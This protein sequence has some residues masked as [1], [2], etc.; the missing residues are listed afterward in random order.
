MNGFLTK[1]LAAV[2]MAASSTA[3]FG[4]GQKGHD[5]T[6]DIAQRHLTK[7]AKKQI[8]ELLDGRSIIYWANWMDNASHTKQ[9]AYTSTWHYRNID[10]DQTFD[11]MPKEEKGDVVNAI[12]AQIE[13]LKS[14]GKTRDERVLALKFLVHLVGDLHCPMHMGHKSDRGGNQWQVQFFNKGTNLHGIY[15]SD[16]VESAHKWTHT[17]WAQELDILSPTQ[18]GVVT[19]GDVDKWARE[20]YAITSRIYDATPVGAKLSYDYVSEWTPTLEQQ[21]LRG[22][23]R[24]AKVLNDIFK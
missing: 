14:Q 17:E 24:L 16:M 2:L 21:F 9:Y 12:N 4:W 7:K 5:I 8:T 1:A 3:V 22:G 10:A 23:L 15:D 11:S 6:C 20:T 18:E 19:E 13:L